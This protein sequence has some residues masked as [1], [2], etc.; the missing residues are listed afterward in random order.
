M[1]KPASMPKF[2]MS[3]LT[4]GARA[5]VVQL[6]HADDVMLGGVVVAQIDARQSHHV[7][8]LQ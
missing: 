1:K 2:S 5:L 7:A 3:T 6:A 8:V 4:T